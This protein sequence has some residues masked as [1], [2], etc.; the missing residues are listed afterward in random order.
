MP[1]PFNSK[2]QGGNCLCVHLHFGRESMGFTN[3]LEELLITTKKFK[4]KPTEKIN[5]Y[6]PIVYHRSFDL[7]WPI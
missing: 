1:L 3:G 4:Q 2:P 5:R 6:F 7:K